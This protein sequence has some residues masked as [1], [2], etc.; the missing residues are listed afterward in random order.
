MLYDNGQLAQTYLDAFRL[1]RILVTPLMYSIALLRAPLQ[2]WQA[3]A[4]ALPW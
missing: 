3:P 1:F 4:S 2:L